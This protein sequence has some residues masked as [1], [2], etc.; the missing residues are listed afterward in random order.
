MI[1]GE[2]L[3]IMT[4]IKDISL[5]QENTL[6]I[7]PNPVSDILKIDFDKVC[8]GLLNVYNEIGQMVF[9]KN[10]EFTKEFNFNAGL[11][12]NGKYNIQFITNNKILNAQFIKVK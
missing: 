9:S 4:A 6:K 7:S 1:K 5:D 12:S 8:S 10:I 3:G 2:D 11:L